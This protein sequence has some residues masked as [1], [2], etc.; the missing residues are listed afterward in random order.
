MFTL[1]WAYETI[2]AHSV[3]EIGLVGGLGA[4]FYP[5]VLQINY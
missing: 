2:Q 1:F 4:F 5:V 3:S